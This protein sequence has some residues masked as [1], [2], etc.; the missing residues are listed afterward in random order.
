M[1]QIEVKRWLVAYEFPPSSGWK[2]TVDID[3]MERA[4]GGIHPVGKKEIAI[5]CEKALRDAGASIVAHPVHGRADLVAEQSGRPTYVVE[6]EGDSSRQREQAMYSALGQLLLS[7]G[8]SEQSIR[9]ALAVPDSGDWIRQVQKIPR[10]VMSRLEMEVLLV[11][12]SGVR[13]A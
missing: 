2:V 8:G 3:A 1:F 6:V 12:A 4:N 11:S 5:E 9:F 10:T 13:R 7:M